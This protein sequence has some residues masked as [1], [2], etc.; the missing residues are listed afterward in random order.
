M[1]SSLRK[2]LHAVRQPLQHPLGAHPVGT[3]AAHDPPR[4]PPFDHGDRP[5]KDRYEPQHQGRHD[6]QQQQVH[7]GGPGPLLRVLPQPLHD[8]PIRQLLH[9]SIS[10]ATTSREPISATRSAIISP[11]L[12]AS[13]APQ[14]VNEP[15][16]IFT[17]NGLSLPSEIA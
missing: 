13:I 10:G 9:R 1:M 5:G 2:L 14:A 12:I 6:H 3:D 11:G 7:R 8:D 17:R 16:R 15:V 4:H